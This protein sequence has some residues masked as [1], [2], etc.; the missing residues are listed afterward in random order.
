MDQ[1]GIMSAGSLKRIEALLAYCAVFVSLVFAI[2]FGLQIDWM[3]AL[4][5][6]TLVTSLS[7]TF[8]RWLS[9]ASLEFCKASALTGLCVF[10]IFSGVG[11]FAM[12]VAESSIPKIAKIRA[13][14]D[15]KKAVLSGYRQEQLVLLFTDGLDA[16]VALQ[17]GKVNNVQIDLTELE[18]KRRKAIA[19]AGEYQ[20]GPFTIFGW[21]AGVIPFATPKLVA[22]ITIIYMMFVA[23][24]A[25]MTKGAILNGRMRRDGTFPRVAND[26]EDDEGDDARPK[27]GPV[28]A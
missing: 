6:G 2:Q 24:C 27:N 11:Y 5:L 22:T 12:T 26:D 14:T 20:A 4:L 25:E 7:L 1:K 15:N 10:T 3:F 9:N 19:D 17:T 21:I 16:A 18:G 23:M 28:A 8:T 13:D